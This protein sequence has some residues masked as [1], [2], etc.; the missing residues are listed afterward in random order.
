MANTNS[1]DRRNGFDKPIDPAGEVP[2]LNVLAATFALAIEALP[3]RTTSETHR[4][5]RGDARLR[6]QVKVARGK[7]ATA[8]GSSGTCLL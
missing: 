3:A 6:H 4:H 7:R 8:H 1:I 2:W 5:L